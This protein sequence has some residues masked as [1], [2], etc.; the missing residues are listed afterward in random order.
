MPNA[1]RHL[2]FTATL[3]LLPL[4]LAASEPT[5]LPTTAPSTDY[6]V[7]ALEPAKGFGSIQTAQF[8]RWGK[9]VFAAWY[10]PTSGLGNCMLHA[11]YYDY[12]KSQWIRFIDTY[13]PTGGDL[14]AEIPTGDDVIVFRDTG[15]K[16][17]VKESIAKFPQ[18]N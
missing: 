18:K 12:D 5:I 11:Y 2:L 14:S 17:V 16:V 6:I 13:V 10:C 9:Q 15:G 4:T 7:K 3:S 8:S 1:I